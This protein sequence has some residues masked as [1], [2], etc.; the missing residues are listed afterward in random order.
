MRENSYCQWN[1][2]PLMALL[3][4]L[5]SGCSMIS[6]EKKDNNHQTL[7][8]L[9]RYFEKAGVQIESVSLIRR[10]IASSDDAAAVKIDG[11]EIG[12][13]KYNTRVKKQREKLEYIKSHGYV[14]LAG[15]KK[16]ALINGSFVMVGSDGNRQ[17]AII[18]KVFNDFR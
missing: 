6:P 8:D 12:L 3:F 13:Y 9:L 14:Y 2:F 11:N 5:V 17:G 15:I 4:L 10:D 7:P 16:K 1:V 18:E